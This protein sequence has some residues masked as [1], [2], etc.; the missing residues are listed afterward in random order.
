MCLAADAAAGVSPKIETVP[1]SGATRPAT[2]RSRVDFPEPER[3]T[4][5][6]K[7]PLGIRIDTSSIAGIS[8][9]G[10]ANVLETPRSST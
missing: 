9:C 2:I 3:P 8:R 7:R 5:D 4:I 6:T 1:S 10:A